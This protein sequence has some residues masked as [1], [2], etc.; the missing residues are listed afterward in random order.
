MKQLMTQILKFGAVGGLCAAIDFG[1]TIVASISFR[2]MGMATDTAALVAAFF[3][4]LI[5]VIVNYILSMKYVFVRDENM[6]RKKE[7]I[8]FIILSVIGLVINELI[9][10]GSMA[11]AASVL[12]ELY[13]NQP[14]L[15]TIGAKVIATGIVMVYNFITRKI[16][17]EK[18]E[19]K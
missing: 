15:V 1:I 6:N 14:T 13:Y 19:N 7:F 10:K 9:I 17:L 11:V 4:F 8:I 5:S 3:G 2:S 12:A 18:K 16:F